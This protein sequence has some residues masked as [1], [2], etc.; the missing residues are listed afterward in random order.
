M[1][2]FQ[3]YCLIESYRAIDHANESL[4]LH[5]CLC[6]MAVQHLYEF[7]RLTQLLCEKYQYRDKVLVGLRQHLES[8]DRIHYG[9]VLVACMMLSWDAHDPDEFS[10]SMQ[11]ILLVLNCENAY[12]DQSDLVQ[13]MLPVAGNQQIAKWRENKSELLGAAMQSLSD[14]TKLV[15]EQPMLLRAARE[16]RNYLTNMLPL[17]NA[18]LSEPAQLKALFPIRSWLP[19]LPELPESI[20]D[21]QHNRFI[22]P[23]LANYEMVKMAQTLV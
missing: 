16:L 15:K 14:L 3:V 7:T 6:G 11:G 1:P 8:G 2:A 22:A 18:M 4:F 21:P 17:Q 12:F 19:W 13:L 9:A 5:D 20:N 10:R 23:F